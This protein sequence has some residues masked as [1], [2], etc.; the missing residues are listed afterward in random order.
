MVLQM[1]H[2]VGVAE[3]KVYGYFLLLRQGTG[4]NI[5]CFLMIRRLEWDGLF[6]VPSDQKLPSLYLLDS[7]V[8]NIGRD[9]IK[10]FAARLPEGHPGAA[11]LRNKPFPHYDDLAH[12]FGKDRATGFSAEGPSDTAQTVDREEAEEN[13]DLYDTNDSLASTQGPPVAASLASTQ[14]PPIA[15]SSDNPS[16]TSTSTSTKRKK[17]KKSDPVFMQLVDNLSNMGKVYEGATESMK[18]LA[19]TF[20]HEADG[21]DRRMKVHEE[22][23][24]AGGGLTDEEI[25]KVGGIITA[26]CNK[27]DYFFTLGGHFKKLY[28]YSLLQ[29]RL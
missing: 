4:G 18:K 16:G 6:F 21:A 9:Y 11:G 12:V 15:R 5:A 8:K 22:L 28:V 26:D 29:K 20:K 7:I 25:V 23:I 13:E 17:G 2:Y 3:D 19:E 1:L 14:G 27:T 24:F 10:Y